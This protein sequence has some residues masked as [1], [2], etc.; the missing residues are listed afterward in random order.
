MFFALLF[1]PRSRFYYYMVVAGIKG[2]LVLQMKMTYADP[3]PYHLDSEIQTTSAKAI[4]GNP[5][6]HS[7][8]AV[9]AAI[10][11]FLD[12]FHG[13]PVTF[14]QQNDSIYHG[15]STYIACLIFAIY[16]SF[17][18]PFARYLAGEHSLDQVVYGF[19]L[20]VYLGFFCHFVMRD[21][22]I[23]FFERVIDWQ[24]TYYSDM[25]FEGNQEER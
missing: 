10:V 5:S 8:A 20:G 6:G 17:T 1:L 13:T 22:L 21:N 19:T 16:W 25:M 15:W 12:V 7:L 2:A 11:I 4:F 3:R 14:H 24:K 23:W 9:V 18:I